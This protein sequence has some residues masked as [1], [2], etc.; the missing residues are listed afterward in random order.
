VLEERNM[1]GIISAGNWIVDSIKIVDC[2]PE[3]GELSNILSESSG[4]GGGPHN[5]LIDIR[6]LGLDIPLMGM[7]CIGRDSNGE[8]LIKE[9]REYGID[10][11]HIRVLDDVSTSY[12]DVFSIAKTGERTF[13]HFRGANALFGPDDV[14]VEAVRRS[15]AKIFQLGYLL[16]LDTMDAP[17]EEYGTAAARTLAKVSE[18]GIKTSLD[19]VSEASDR[20]RRLVEPA[21]PHVDYCVINEVE[22]QKVTGIEIRRRSGAIDRDALKRAAARLLECG[23]RSLAVIHFPEGCLWKDRE[24]NEMYKPSFNIPEEQIVGSAGAGDAFC[25]GILVG[26]HE[27][28]EPEK[29]MT[30]ANAVAC[31]CLKA[32]NTTDGVVSLADIEREIIGKLALRE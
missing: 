23:V 19:V 21:L 28:W 25:A 13:F 11:T 32:A 26:L 5:V 2:W 16:L 27:G 17:D 4:G 7:G 30:V 31:S 24:A 1:S 6:K 20:F 22:A 29:C 10:S 18:T 15:G 8:F 12:T 14:P 3:K 9:C